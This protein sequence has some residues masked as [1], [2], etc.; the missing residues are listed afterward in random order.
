M[1]EKA[2]GALRLTRDLILQ[3]GVP[4]LLTREV[5]MPEWG[6][7]VTVRQFTGADTD[8]VT[9]LT[10]ERGANGRPS[11]NRK[12]VRAVIII[13]G[14]VDANGNRLFTLEDADFLESLPV[15]MTNRIIEALTELNGGEDLEADL[16]KNSDGDPSEDSPS[17]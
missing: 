13:R 10:E 11:V 1:V 7:T 9:R 12:K 17:S 3:K 4:E 14:V 2:R 15:S 8:Y 6:G 16:E 5:E